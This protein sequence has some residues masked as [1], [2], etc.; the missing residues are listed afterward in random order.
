MGGAMAVVM[1]IEELH[2]FLA[3]AFAQVADDFVVEDVSEAALTMRLVVSDKHLRP[4]GTVSGPAMFG[5]ADV[6]IY[7]TILSAIGPKG[8]VVTTNSS[9]DFMRKPKPGHD[10][11]CACRLLKLGRSLAVGDALITSVGDTRP[12]A[13]ASMTYAIPPAGSDADRAF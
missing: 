13:R 1:G 10:L 12:V 3:R 2:Q 6:A 9:I 4:G 5:L 8:L 7:L 11:L